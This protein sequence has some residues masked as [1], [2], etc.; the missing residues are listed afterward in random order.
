MLIFSSVA[1]D[2]EAQSIGSVVDF[3]GIQGGHD[4][5]IEGLAT[6]EISYSD[7]CMIE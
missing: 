5:L 4:G 7:R 2:A 3:L 1:P 6:I